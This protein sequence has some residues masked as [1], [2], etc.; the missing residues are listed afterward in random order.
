MSPGWINN[1]YDE[2]Q[3]VIALNLQFNFI[4]LYFTLKNLEGISLPNVVVGTVKTAKA[5]NDQ[6]HDE[7]QNVQSGSSRLN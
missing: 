1:K 5:M 7:A 3:K 4:Y 2:L 6:R